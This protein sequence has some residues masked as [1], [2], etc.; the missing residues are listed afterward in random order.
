MA[1]NPTLGKNQINAINRVLSQL[2]TGY[3]NM[4]YIAELIFPMFRSDQQSGQFRK[5]QKNDRFRLKATA[6]APGTKY[7]TSTWG[8]GDPGTYNC[9]NYSH[10]ERLLDHTLDIADDAARPLIRTTTMEL[11]MDALFLSMEKRV[12]DM[13]NTSGNWSSNSDTATNI[14]GAQFNDDTAEVIKGGLDIR[15]TFRTQMGVY[16]NTVVMGAKTWQALRNHPDMLARVEGGATNGQPAM[17]T[18]QLLQAMWE[19]ERILIGTAIYDTSDQG[20]ES[21]MSDIWDGDYCWWGYVDAAP[22]FMNPTA[23]AI[24]EW[25]PDYIG[26]PRQI[27]EFRYDEEGFTKMVAEHFVDEVVVSSE[28]GLLVSDCL[29]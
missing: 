11:A 18:V 4:Q 10:G 7:S 13:V 22:A 21:S 23:G 1:Y 17:V 9:E 28:A 24:V 5:L 6:H 27:K 8:M 16:P 14:F 20:E 2:A 3:S 25:V 19:M 15:E 12:A 26:V 29:A